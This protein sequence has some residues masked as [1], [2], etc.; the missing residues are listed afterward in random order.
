[1]NRIYITTIVLI[2]A[3]LS[4]INIATSQ[5]GMYSKH[6]LS[7]SVSAGMSNLIYK[8]DESS[9]KGGFGGK[10]EIGYTYN[11]DEQFGIVT[12]LGIALYNSK[13][14]MAECSGKSRTVDNLMGDNYYSEFNYSLAEY[15]EKHHVAMVTIPVMARYIMWLGASPFRYYASGGLKF[16]I[17]TNANA[18]IV[19]GTITTSGYYNYENGTYT[20]LPEYGFVTG[21]VGEQLNYKMKLGIATFLALETGVR[22][23]IAYK[24]DLILSIYLD[25]SLNNVQKIN[26]KHVLEYQPL[27][28]SQFFYN[29]VINSNQISK[30]RLFS[31]GIK[32]GI[33]F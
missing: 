27:Y 32:V 6:E 20:D 28:S 16:G 13:L 25:Y 11:V 24:M 22:T 14:N 31:T 15:S 2:T 29:S 7:V 26:N 30:A 10:F 1:M 17:P 3:C 5:N 33:S 21:E 19:P 12:G 8:L 18:S 4:T 23:E 9:R